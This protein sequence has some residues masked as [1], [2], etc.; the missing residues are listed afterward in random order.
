MLGLILVG[1]PGAAPLAHNRPE[2]TGRRWG[3]G[4]GEGDG[5]DGLEKSSA[6]CGDGLNDRR[7]MEVG[8]KAN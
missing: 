7:G 4:D 2:K 6:W 8:A 3:G 1:E 5:V